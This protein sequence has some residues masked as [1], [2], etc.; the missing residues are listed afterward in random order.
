MLAF[1]KLAP[2]GLKALVPNFC[3]HDFKFLIVIYNLR[4]NLLKI[5]LMDLLKVKQQMGHLF[6]IR[7]FTTSKSLSVEVVNYRNNK[8]NL[9]G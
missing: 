4:G 5:L 3:F 2:Y 1:S 6:D 7:N 8:G 9:V